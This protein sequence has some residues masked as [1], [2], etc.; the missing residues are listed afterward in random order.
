MAALKQGLKS[1]RLIFSLNK[2]YSDN[3]EQMLIR[4]RKYAQTE[5]EESIFH[6]ARKEKDGKKGIRKKIV[7]SNK[8]ILIDLKKI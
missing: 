7:K 1:N 4:V 3:Y 6:Q 2:N 5:E 8:I